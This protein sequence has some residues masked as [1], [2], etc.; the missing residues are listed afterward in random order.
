MLHFNTI[1]GVIPCEYPDKLTS[2][3]TRMIC[4][5]DAET[6]TI[7]RIFTRLDK[8]PAWAGRTNERTDRIALAITA[9]CIASNVDAL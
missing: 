9:V 1:A 5:R 4:L 8:T 6:R 3:E 2:P 7:V